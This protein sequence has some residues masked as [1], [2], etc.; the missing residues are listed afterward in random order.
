MEFYPVYPGMPVYEIGSPI[1][2]KSVIHLANR[3]QFTTV[4]H[5][6]S[7]QNKCIQSAQTAEQAVVRPVRYCQG[8]NAYA[9]DGGSAE[10][11]MGQLS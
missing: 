7:A 8:G 2:E 3:K 6:A 9:G 5:H 10:C 1:F 11:A 4:A